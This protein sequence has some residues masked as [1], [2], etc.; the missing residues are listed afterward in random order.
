VKTAIFGLEPHLLTDDVLHA[1]FAVV[2]EHKE[3]IQEH[4]IFRGVKW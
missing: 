4:K 1:M 2:E 3:N